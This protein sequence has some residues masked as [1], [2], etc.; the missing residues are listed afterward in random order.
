MAVRSATKHAQATVIAAVKKRDG[1]LYLAA[2]DLDVTA[3]T[4][5]NYAKRWPD[6]RQAI[7]EAK[8]RLLDHAESKLFQAI[9]KGE[10]WA[11]CFFLKCQ[12]KRRGY[13]ERSE[14]RHGGDPKAPIQVAPARDIVDL[15]KLN[16]PL[17]C[18]REVMDAIRRAEHDA[19]SE[20]QETTDG[21]ALQTVAK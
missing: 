4:L 20:G 19:G 6:V 5:R 11:V 3:Q 13:V 1:K 7:R 9:D 8:G 18:R 14:L 17:N 10:A 15:D 21:K 12:G 2:A 16:L